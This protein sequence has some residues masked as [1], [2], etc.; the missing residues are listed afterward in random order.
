MKSKLIILSLIMSSNVFAYRVVSDYKPAIQ[1]PFF[2]NDILKVIENRYDNLYD[3]AVVSDGKDTEYASLADAL[4]G[5]R[6]VTKKYSQD[7]FDLYLKRANVQGPG[8][9]KVKMD[10]FADEIAKEIVNDSNLIKEGKFIDEKDKKIYTLVKINK[11]HVQ[12]KVKKAFK[13]RLGL[14][15]EDLEKLRD[16]L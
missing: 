16:E 6:D 9:N 4:D 1:N 2:N 3:L 11:I 14:V 15:I 12:R 8:F 13:D 5:I 7:L 10:E